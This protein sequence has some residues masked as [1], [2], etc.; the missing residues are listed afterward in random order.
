M[1]HTMEEEGERG[2]GEERMRDVIGDVDS[3]H[4]KT[5]RL[6]TEKVRG[7]TGARYPISYQKYRVLKAVAAGNQY[8]YDI[9]AHANVVNSTVQ[10]MLDGLYN[11]GWLTRVCPD[12]RTYIWGISDEGVAVLEKLDSISKSLEKDVVKEI[13]LLEEWVA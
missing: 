11:S 12:K 7:L 5:M 6:W 3:V 2:R 10:L 13:K 1:E 8:A 9:Y 4:K